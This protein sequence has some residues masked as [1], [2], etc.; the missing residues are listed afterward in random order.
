MKKKDNYS[1]LKNDD[2][3]LVGLD[4][5]TTKIVIVAG[6]LND[7]NQIEIIGSG[8][9]SSTGVEFGSIYNLE[10]TINEIQIA[11]AQLV[12]D[13]NESI[14]NVYVG[15][16]GKHINNASYNHHINRANGRTETIKKEEIDRLVQEINN[17]A[18]EPGNE[19]IAVI[20][21]IYTIDNQR[22]TT[23]PIGEFGSVLG[24]TFQ[25]VL[26]NSFEIEKIIRAVHGADL[27]AKEIIL[28]PQASGLSALSDEEKKE[29]V[30]LIDIG[31][32]TSDVA[33][34]NNGNLCYTKVIPLGGT[35]IT[36]DIQ[37]AC[38][39]IQEHAEYIKIHYG[40]CIANPEYQSQKITIPK[41]YNRPSKEI[42][43]YFLA[44]VIA[45]RANQIIEEIAKVI[46]DSGYNDKIPYGI[47]LT[48]GG[49][50]LKNI[51]S[52]CEFHTHKQVRIAI[53]EFGFTPNMNSELKRPE[54][55]TALGLLK[56][57]ALKNQQDN[58]EDNHE[59]TIT[60]H[61]PFSHQ[62]SHNK[63]KKENN[64]KSNIGLQVIQK[65]LDTILETNS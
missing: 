51:K 37:K 43:I 44:Q 42:P 26:G 47:V 5:G 61:K 63:T 7:E 29:G 65:W 25:L 60:S 50:N 20:P 12:D 56:Y 3:V 64:Q 35:L 59:K 17:L 54:Y 38:S 46:K 30:V 48:G 41:M 19:L 58:D 49:A 36:N 23:S 8:R 52:L 28:E 45:A 14:E 40:D 32:G 9:T 11:A 4:I 53:P 22:K 21:Q 27:T 31:G 1:E 15:I 55:A 24:A 34:Y 2:Q 10:K 16:A 13:I 62:S 39:V 6:K 33:I 18:L 57:A